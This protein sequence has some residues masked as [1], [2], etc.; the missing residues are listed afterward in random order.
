MR[1]LILSAL[2]LSSTP[3]FASPE[4]ITVTGPKKEK[5]ICRRDE[6]SVSATRLSKRVCKTE[7]EW[8]HS[9]EEDQEKVELLDTRQGPRLPSA[10][11]Q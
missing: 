4:P 10:V 8:R 5:K 2:L 3:S 11:P 9:A 7:A 1:I 6:T